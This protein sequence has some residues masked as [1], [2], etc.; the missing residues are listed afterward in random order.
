MLVAAITILVGSITARTILAA[1]RG[2]L[3]PSPAAAALRWTPAR[4]L[5][6]AGAEPPGPRRI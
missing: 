6:P 1:T 4:F 2:Q 3:L 5:N